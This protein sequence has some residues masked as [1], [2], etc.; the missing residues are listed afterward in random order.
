MILVARYVTAMAILLLM[1]G[2][3]ELDTKG[4]LAITAHEKNQARHSCVHIKQQ[5]C[6]PPP[7]A[8]IGDMFR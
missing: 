3:S 1:L 7:N 6:S 4:Q 8:S 5:V 2:C